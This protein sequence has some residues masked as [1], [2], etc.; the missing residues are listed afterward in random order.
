M[1]NIYQSRNIMVIDPSETTRILLKHHLE[2]Q[3]AVVY[4]AGVVE[5]IKTTIEGTDR[6]GMPIDLI[7]IDVR[8][9]DTYAFYALKIVQ[10]ALAGRH[11]PVFVMSSGFPIS[12]IRQMKQWGAFG[13]LRKPFQLP[14]LDGFLDQRLAAYK[15]RFGEAEKVSPAVAKQNEVRLAS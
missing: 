15:R 5:K 9:P 3:G 4:T 14:M 11:I 1:A 6:S 7:L 10:S 2:C 13:Y 12:A 8:L